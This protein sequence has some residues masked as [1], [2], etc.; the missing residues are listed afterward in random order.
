MAHE[1][2]LRI[3]KTE[4]TIRDKVWFPGI[5]KLADF[6]VKRHQP[7]HHHK[8]QLPSGPYEEDAV[9]FTGP[10]PSGEYIINGGIQNHAILAKSK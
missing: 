8:T 9:H 5:D 6:F 10:F 1:V 7:S 2:Q 3:I 4:Q